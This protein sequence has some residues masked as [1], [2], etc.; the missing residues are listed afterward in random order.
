MYK[1]T[2]YYG[3]FLCLESG[4]YTRR[5]KCEL[6]LKQTPQVRLLRDNPLFFFFFFFDLEGLGH[7]IPFSSLV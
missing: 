2:E 4:P 6:K 3:V 5:T 7:P 1:Y